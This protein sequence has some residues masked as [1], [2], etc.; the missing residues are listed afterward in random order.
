MED[1]GGKKKLTKNSQ[2]RTLHAEFWVKT[3]KNF[4]KKHTNF[5]VNS[6]S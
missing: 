2:N 5:L 4:L 1:S 3:H 6:P